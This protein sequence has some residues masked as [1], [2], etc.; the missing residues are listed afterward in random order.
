MRSGLTLVCDWYTIFCGRKPALA[1]E[2]L[3]R[4]LPLPTEQEREAGESCV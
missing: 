1:M 2:A 4:V 3:S